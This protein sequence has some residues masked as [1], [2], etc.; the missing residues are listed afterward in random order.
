MI[1]SI[2]EQ[3]KRKKEEVIMRIVK[4]SGEVF[5]FDTIEGCQAYFKYVLPWQKGY[6]GFAGTGNKIAKDKLSKNETILFS[7][8]GKI[9]TAAKAVEPIIDGNKVIG[10]MI[11]KESIKVLKIPVSTFDL[12]K[13]L[14]KH[15]FDDSIYGSQGWNIIPYNLEKRVI[16][17]LRNEE[18]KEYSKELKKE[19]EKY[20][21]N[22]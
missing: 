7:Y 6:F 20:E 22:L 3:G 4:M 21:M 9:V 19:W 14:G 15:G 5:G 13:E 12:E 18:L 2:L 10:I 8:D 16:E 1:Y 11:N 17:F